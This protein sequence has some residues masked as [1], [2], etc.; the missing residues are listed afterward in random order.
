MQTLSLA[1]RSQWLD[2]VIQ[3]SLPDGFGRMQWLLGVKEL[4]PGHVQIPYVDQQ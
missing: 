3:T 2:P 1:V 4:K